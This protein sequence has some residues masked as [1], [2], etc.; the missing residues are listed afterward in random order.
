MRARDSFAHEVTSTRSRC[1]VPRLR[2]SPMGSD[3]G[4][5]FSPSI[6]TWVAC[7][8]RCQYSLS[9]LISHDMACQETQ[10]SVD[11]ARWL[12][13]S[14]VLDRLLAHE[15]CVGRIKLRLHRGRCRRLSFCV[16]QCPIAVTLCFAPMLSSWSV[17]IVAREEVEKSGRGSFRSKI[18]NRLTWTLCLAF[19]S[20][21]E[22][23]PC[24]LA[25]TPS[26]R[27]TAHVLFFARTRAAVVLLWCWVRQWGSRATSD[28]QFGP[29]PR[30]PSPLP[31]GCLVHGLYGR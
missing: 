3:S 2:C 8:P 31:Q 12:L 19:A 16:C 6:H 18:L 30:H 15:E 5:S 22:A 14:L 11:C 17:A 1:P 4:A 9:L 27:A 23:F 26:E 29:V 24:R 20:H 28:R 25:P 13:G 7:V 10:S 21:G